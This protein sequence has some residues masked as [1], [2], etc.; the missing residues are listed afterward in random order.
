[1]VRTEELQL[2]VLIDGSPARKELAELDQE[3]AKLNRDMKDLAKS[4]KEWIAANERIGQIG[5][6]QAELRAQIGLTGLTAK[7]LGD[8]LRRLQVTQ[9]NLTPNTPMWVENAKRIQDVKNRLKELNDVNALA[10]AAWDQ[11]RRSIKL[12]NMSMEQL[13]METRRLKTALHT[14]DPNTAQFRAL[15]HELKGVETRMASLRTGMGP[16]ARTWQDLKGAIVTG[17]VAGAAIAG[18]QSLT[19]AIR[20]SFTGML[21]LS[22]QLTAVEK[23][24]GLTSKETAVLNSELSKVDRRTSTKSLRDIAISLGQLNQEVSATNVVAIDKIVSALGDEF[25]DDAGGITKAI[26]IL[27]NNLVDL[28]TEDFGTDVLHI[29]NALNELGAKGLATAPVVTDIANRIAGVSTTLGVTSG[30]ILGT[31]AAFQELGINVER[32]STAYVKTLQKIASAPKD[33]AVVV[34]AAGMDVKK[35]MRLVDED[36][37]SAMLMV[38]QATTIAGTTNTKYAA[39]LK[40]LDTDGAGVSELL[41]KMG[42]NQQIFQEKTELATEALKE[43]S[44]ILEEDAKR[45]NNLAGQWERM[46]KVFERNINLGAAAR[47]LGEGLAYVIDK[48]KAATQFFRDWYA[49][50][51]AF[52]IGIEGLMF[53]VKNSIDIFQAALD[54]AIVQPIKLMIAG[55]KALRLVMK[56]EFAA[57]GDEFRKFN[58]QFV[59]SMKENA[60]DLADNFRTAV[61]NV[62]DP[63]AFGPMAK[64]AKAAFDTTQMSVEEMRAK[65]DQLLKLREAFIKQG[66]LEA[67]GEGDGKI[68]Q[69][70]TSIAALEAGDPPSAAGASLPVVDDIADAAREKA[71]AERERQIGD[72]EKMRQ[73]M[74]DLR[75]QMLFDAMTADGRELAQVAKKYDE[76]RAALVANEL[77][78]SEDLAELDRVRD[79]AML[80]KLDEQGQKRIAKARE[81]ALAEQAA[82]AAAEDEV[83]LDQQATDEDK[84]ITQ[85]LQRM[86]ALVALYEKAGIDTQGIVERT[87]K[88]VAAIRRKYR[89]QEQAD[90][91]KAKQEA[92]AEKVAV[93][94]AVGSALNGVNALMSAGMDD[95]GKAH[96]EQT[97]A[98]KA[99][100][101]AQIAIASGVGVAE[102]IKAGAGLTFPANLGAIAT[103]VGAVLTGIA[104][105]MNLLN[106]A[107]VEQPNS[108]GAQTSATAT[109]S[110]VPYAAKGG[111]FEGPSHDEDGLKVVDPRNNRI[112]AEVEGGEPWMV[113]SKAFRQKNARIIP[114]LLQAS[115]DGTELAVVPKKPDRIRPERTSDVVGL[116]NSSANRVGTMRR[117]GVFGAV[118]PFNFARANEVVEMAQGGILQRGAVQD[119]GRTLAV[120]VKGATEAGAPNGTAQQNEDGQHGAAMSNKQLAALVDLQQRMLDAI[121]AGTWAKVSLQDEERSRI[122]YNQI[123]NANRVKKVAA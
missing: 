80:A 28:R 112:V 4:S 89:T 46:V 45:Q 18:F 95:W 83:F 106:R 99:L 8:E 107:K 104:N 29:G 16:L 47:S 61:K 97:V 35:F 117:G 65:L 51:A 73:E 10:D 30:Q 119:M 81:H 54:I 33:F 23:A 41:S 108:S 48:T 50:S 1:M 19:A 64:N 93:Y 66:K 91:A 22:D 13:E 11:Q 94:Q 20:G 85:E 102:A 49:E 32:G 70:Q 38:A 2:R 34:E 25:G 77:A 105:A 7:Q 55:V 121:E 42:Q 69:L 71:K 100:G 43:H 31:G 15:S 72:L 39:T 78:T 53:T 122:E 79:E 103:G 109:P 116:F 26:S 37:H 98:A 36:L 82:R 68:A 110:R 21:D 87:E 56:G 96:Y 63:N 84:S 12:T 9:R 52:R 92:I 57:A 115:A 60:S 27:R 113:L 90:A 17:G 101:L 86:D 59:A 44:S 6:R 24:A 62:N 118:P 123:R 40:E 111:V 58:A 74:K 114:L 14:L 3:Y 5:T 120:A 76:M 88:A 75:E 67:A